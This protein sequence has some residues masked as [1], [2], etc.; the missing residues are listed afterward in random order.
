MTY[1]LA[2]KTIDAG[3]V[4]HLTE[5]LKTDPWLS[6]GA[7][8]KRFERAWTDIIGTRFAVY[9]NSGSSAN[10]LMVAVMAESYRSAKTSTRRPTVVVPAVSWATTVMPVIQL[11]CNPILCDADETTWGLDPDHLEQICKATDVHAVLVVHV[12]GVPAQIQQI[13]EIQNRYGFWILEDSCASPLSTFVDED[14][15]IPR[16]IGT[17]GEMSSTSL[18]MG[19]VRSTIEGGIVCTDSV[20]GYE[21]LLMMR[22]HGWA[23]DV[24]LDRQVDLADRY[25]IPEFNRVFT[26]YQLGYNVRPTDLGACLG[27]SQLENMDE[28]ARVRQR[29]HEQYQQYFR[30]HLPDF[31]IQE[32]PGS[33]ICS[34]SFAA[35]APTTG[36]RDRVTRHIQSQG[37]ETRPVG[38]GSMGRQPFWIDRYGE[39]RLTM[40]DAVHDRS[41]LLPNHHHL[42]ESDVAVICEHAR[43]GYERGR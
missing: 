11:G 16:R 40:A 1:H 36:D 33:V 39:Q 42:T 9:V 27:V 34:I 31:A 22:S 21:Q 32:S 6:M 35:L 18:Y 25:Q 12:M 2:E 5:W 38:G 17:C 14:G 23:K 10:L 30:S 43:E 8:T 13:E 7:M 26:F 28:V 29:N 3:D 20:I 24:S 41:F 15:A 37:V 19:H 4:H